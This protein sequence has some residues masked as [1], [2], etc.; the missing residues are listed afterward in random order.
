MKIFK[1]ILL[2]ILILFIVLLSGGWLF[3]HHMQTQ[4]EKYMG[5]GFEYMHGYSS[6]DL[7][8]YHVYD[9]DKLV[10]L[11]HAP[12]FM[13]DSIEDKYNSIVEHLLFIKLSTK[14]FLLPGNK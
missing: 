11:N 14:G 9:G 1:K 2:A 7:T 3:F 13:I 5:H 8:G 12:E 6:T 4:K 10:K